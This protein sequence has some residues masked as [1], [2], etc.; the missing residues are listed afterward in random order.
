[1]LTCNTWPESVLKR[2]SRQRKWQLQKVAEGL[3]C[4][5]GKEPL[6]N[7]TLGELCREKSRAS[8]REY[9]AL[10]RDRKRKNGR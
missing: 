6:V 3:C 5:C 9:S 1:M 7:R 8:G 10:Y 2:V 4:Q